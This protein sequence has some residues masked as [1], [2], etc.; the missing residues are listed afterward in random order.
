M[1]WFKFKWLTSEEREILR[2]AKESVVYSPSLTAQTTAPFQ[3]VSDKPYQKMYYSNQNLTVVMKDGVVYSKSHVATDEFQRM[4]D[5]STEKEIEIFFTDN[6]HLHAAPVQIGSVVESADERDLVGRNLGIL[7]KNPAFVV[8]GDQAFLKGV[9]LPM[10]APVIASFIELLEKKEAKDLQGLQSDDCEIQ[11]QLEALQM[12]WLKLALNP[13][14]QSREDLLVFVRHNDVRITR[15]GNL[16]LYRRIITVAGADTELVKSVTQEYYRIK[17]D[18]LDPREFAL[19]KHADGYMA[20]HLES[21]DLPDPKF[22]VGNLQVMYLE[23][24]NM[25]TNTFTAAH[26]KNMKIQIGGIYKIPE[27]K[28]NLNNGLCAAGGLHAAAV[29]YNYSGFGDMPV[30][31]LVNPSKAI[32]VP[33]N[34]VGKLRTTEMFIACVND[35]PQGTHF[36][37]SALAA[38]DSEYHDLSLE[39]LEEAARTKSFEGLSVVDN[40]PAISLIDLNK[41]KEML[42]N[43]VKTV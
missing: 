8:Q 24:P 38:F 29:D 26:D 16:I 32:T 9:N 18:G 12:F 34:E 13:L 37:D 39:E 19:V 20:C 4:R 23:L 43:R 6:L 36:D 15:N 40:V 17:K 30:V 1:K 14:P 25:D 7:K 42:K 5:A 41:I 10:P 21:P 2:R 3:Y 28:I 31:V 27:N 22:L 35:K 11:S 33:R